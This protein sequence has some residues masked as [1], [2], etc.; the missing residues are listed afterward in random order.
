[1]IAENEHNKAKRLKALEDVKRS[2]ANLIVEEIKA[3]EVADR[4]REDQIRER[5]DKIQKIMNQMGDVVQVGKEKELRKKAERDYIDECI[6]KDEEAK[7]QDLQ[8]K[9]FKRKKNIEVRSFLEN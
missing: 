3:R 9:L 7:R 5:D 2:D 4:K 8:A 1:M 6:R